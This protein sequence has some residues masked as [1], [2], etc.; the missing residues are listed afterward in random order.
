MEPE[1]RQATEL[2]KREA[3]NEGREAGSCNFGVDNVKS[4]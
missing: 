1:I 4:Q 2:A 3:W